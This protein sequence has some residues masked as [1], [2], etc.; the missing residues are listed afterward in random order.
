M[1]RDL[2]EKLRKKRG[3]FFGGYSLM[4]SKQFNVPRIIIDQIRTYAIHR[5]MNQQEICIYLTN[6]LNRGIYETV[7]RSNR[8]MNVKQ[9]IDLKEKI[10]KFLLHCNPATFSVITKL[11]K[12]DWDYEGKDKKV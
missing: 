6:N 10:L 1:K 5:K 3:H 2:P 12:Y 8:G 9:Y 7:K 4:L 11:T